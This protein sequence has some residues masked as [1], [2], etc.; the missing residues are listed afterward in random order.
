MKKIFLVVLFVALGGLTIAQTMKNEHQAPGA[1]TENYNTLTPE[2]RR[3]IL[4]KGTE[5]PYSGKYYKHNDSGTYVCRQC[6]APLYRSDDKFDSGCGWPSFDDEIPGAVKRLRDADGQRTEILCNTCGGHLGHVFEGEGFT[7]KNTRHCVN[8]VSMSFVPA[9]AETSGDNKDATLPATAEAIFAGGCFWGVE[10]LMQQQPGVISV[11]SGYIGGTVDN[12]TYEQ[13]CSKQTGHAEAVKVI[14]DPSK[15][16]YE[17]LTKLFF[18]IHDPTQA[19]GQGPD[20]GPQYRSE[21]FYHTP[22][23]KAIAE[24]LIGQLRSNGYNVVTAV[25]PA[26]TF[27]PAEDYHQDYYDN[28]GTQP[29]CHAYTKRF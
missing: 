5:M 16:N 29:Y 4:N 14:Y 22:E 1:R 26:T 9:G 7:D 21:I 23:E 20:I 8:S 18:E 15:V 11:E 19:N 24:K 10:H 13:V 2:E 12:P 28:K 25:T 27:W 17:T 6:D 3:V